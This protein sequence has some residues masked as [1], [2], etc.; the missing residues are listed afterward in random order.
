MKTPRNLGLAALAVFIISHFLPAYGTASG[1]TCFK[2]CANGLWG[3]DPEVLSGAWFYYSGLAVANVLFVGL[4]VALMVTRKWRRL[5]TILSVVCLLHV[6][7]WLVAHIF[8]TPSEV[9]EIKIGYY[10]WL[11]AYA[12]L[13]AAHLCKES[14]ELTESNPVAH[15]VV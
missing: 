15:S 14:T 12:L 4:V 5:R 10:V 11:I 2:V 3:H 1:F 6:L 8:Q 13:A 9:S 7:S